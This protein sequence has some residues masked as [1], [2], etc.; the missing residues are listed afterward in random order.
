VAKKKKE[1]EISFFPHSEEDLTTHM[2][3]LR[4]TFCG[5]R[6]SSAFMPIST[7]F[8]RSVVVRAVISCPD[9][10]GRLR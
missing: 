3:H 9:C 10:I 4:C 2:H 6:V 1:A 7:E 8:G 5:V